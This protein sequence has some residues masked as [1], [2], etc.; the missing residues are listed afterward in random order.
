MDD[1]AI[2]GDERNHQ[3]RRRV[4][5]ACVIGGIA[6][7]AL[8][9]V[10]IV[11]VAAVGLYAFTPPSERRLA[12]M[13]KEGDEIVL[14]IEAHKAETGDYPSRLAETQIVPPSHSLRMWVY[15][16]LKDP[17][18]FQLS[19]FFPNHG[20]LMYNPSTGWEYIEKSSS[21]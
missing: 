16:Q 21:D 10:G 2:G 6:G 19:M 13:Q 7:I 8:I 4:V 5:L 11:V 12:A 3:Q 18:G 17:H 9:G 1:R 20:W 15:H 14:Q